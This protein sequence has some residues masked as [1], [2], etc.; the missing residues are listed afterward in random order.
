MTNEQ[1]NFIADFIHYMWQRGFKCYIEKGTGRSQ[2]NRQEKTVILDI[3]DKDLFEKIYIA[4]E[5][6]NQILHKEQIQ[7]AANQ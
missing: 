6:A 5:I 3:L 1:V 4:K 2:I 7:A